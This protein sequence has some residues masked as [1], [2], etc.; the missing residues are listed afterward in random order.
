[1][2]LLQANNQNEVKS[3]QSLLVLGLSLRFSA[4]RLSGSLRLVLFY[5]GEPQRIRKEPQRPAKKISTPDDK[6][7]LRIK[8]VGHILSCCDGNPEPH[9]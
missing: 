8:G 3:S 1:M 7:I 2:A 9:T 5:R 6:I 4:K